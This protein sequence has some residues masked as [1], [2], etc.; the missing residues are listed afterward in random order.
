[1]TPIELTHARSRNQSPWVPERGGNID[2]D[3]AK[4]VLQN[5]GGRNPYETSAN[6]LNRS[7]VKDYDVAIDAEYPRLPDRIAGAYYPRVRTLFVDPR[8]KNW[9]ETSYHEL[10]H[11]ADFTQNPK[12]KGKHEEWVGVFPRKET[13][14]HFAN[15][16]DRRH[17]YM[18][19]M[20][21]G[22]E[23]TDILDFS[24][25]GP[26]YPG[27]GPFQSTGKHGKPIPFNVWNQQSA[28]MIPN[29]RQLPDQLDRSDKAYGIPL[30][31]EMTDPKNPWRGYGSA[32]G[33]VGEKQLALENIWKLFGGIK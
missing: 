28:R 9:P 33:H 16:K 11:F 2:E 10:Q 3:F 22:A 17:L 32:P 26:K 12:F 18:D 1:M 5:Y 30:P 4:Y 24:K 29:E 7:A 20:F 8:K 19:E 27:V 14:E 31:P 21:P 13:G 15:Y 25:V 23:G 6:I